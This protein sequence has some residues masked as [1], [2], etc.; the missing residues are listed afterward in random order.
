M[1]VRAASADPQRTTQLTGVS[2]KTTPSTVSAAQIFDRL[3]AIVAE[4][5][6]AQ[7][8]RDGGNDPA[9]Q[10]NAQNDAAAPAPHQS[11]SAPTQNVASQL[12]P[13]TAPAAPAQANAATPI[14]SYAAVDPQAVIEQLVKSITLRTSDSSSEVRMRLQPEHLGNVALKLTVTG[15]TISANV[16]AQSAHVRDLLL[17]NQ[18]QLARSLA[19][20][21]LS[22]GKFSVDVSGG[23]PGFA[24]RQSQGHRLTKTGALHGI[25]D[26]DPIGDDSR[27]G[28]PLLAANSALV[29]NYLA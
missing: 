1:L 27:F 16:V 3:I 12:T 18:Q 28:P 23:N 19:D 7:T 25:D 13:A 21:G 17:A 22:L 6:G 14:T 8:D 24:Q 5:A 11:A 10:S 26:E 9:G 20:A 29:L 4:H 2:T 15:N